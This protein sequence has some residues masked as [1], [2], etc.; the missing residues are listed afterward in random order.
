MSSTGY[1]KNG[2]YYK[3]KKVPIAGLVK[4][5]QTMYKQGDHA[6]QRFDHSAEILQPRDY[7][8]DPNPKFIEAFPDA[9][10]EYGFTPNLEPPAPR[11]SDTPGPGSKDFGG[12]I[13][14]GQVNP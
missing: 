5:Q 6:R 13:P 1:I 14:W 10:V 9:A 8:G 7:K 12:S 3:A 2:V 11:E 4:T